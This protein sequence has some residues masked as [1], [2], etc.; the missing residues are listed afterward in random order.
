MRVARL[1]CNCGRRNLL[2]VAPGDGDYRGKLI[3]L[4]PTPVVAWCRECWYA[5]FGYL[6]GKPGGDHVRRRTPTKPGRKN[7]LPDGVE[8]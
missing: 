2:A 5:R 4:K 7:P 1:V 6:V 8:R 3:C